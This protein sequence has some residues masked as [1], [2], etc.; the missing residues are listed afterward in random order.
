VALKDKWKKRWKLESFSDSSVEYT[1]ALDRD[2]NYGCSC[3]AWRFGRKKNPFCKHIHHVI[4]LNDRERA[5]LLVKQYNIAPLLTSEWKVFLIEDNT[6]E[7]HVAMT[8]PFGDR[9]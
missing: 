9:E 6:G 3:P 7:V 4:S 2:D 1:V 8:R 5:A